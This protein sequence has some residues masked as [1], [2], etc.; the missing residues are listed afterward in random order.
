[1]RKRVFIFAGIVSCL[2]TVS[3]AQDDMICKRTTQDVFLPFGIY[4]DQD[5]VQLESD[6]AQIRQT[7]TSVFIGNVDVLHGGQ[8]LN[9]DYATYNQQTGEL[10]ASGNVRV[11]DT[12][13]V[14]QGEE[15]EWSMVDDEGAMLNVNYQTREMNARG[16]ADNV[17]RQGVSWTSMKNATYTTC[18]HGDNAWLLS[19]GRVYLDHD[20]AVGEATNVVL[21][22]K[23]L[24]VFYTP[25][26]SFPLDDERKSGFLTPSIGTSSKNGFDATTPY[27]WNIA[28]NR[29]ATITPRYMADR[30]LMLSGQYRY[31]YQRGAGQ[32]EA[33][34]LSSDRKQRDGEVLN[35]NYR[36]DRK[37][38][39]LQ[40]QGRTASNWLTQVDYNYVSDQQ[41]LEDF[42]NNL[43]ISSTTH[44]NRLLLV[45]YSSQN[46][47]LDARLHGYQT[48]ADVIKPY[49]RLPQIVFRSTLPDQAYGLTY[50]TRAEYVLFDHSDRVDGQRVDLEP[51]ISLPMATP[52]VFFTPRVALRHTR[53]DL[54]NTSNTNFD[55]TITRTLPVLSLDSGLFFDRPLS[56]RGSS[57]TQTLEPRAFYLYIPE[58]NQESIPVFDTSV[59]QFARASLYTYDR[60]TGP[61]RVGDAN[62]LTVGVTSRF[63]NNR[64]GREGFRMSIGQIRYFTN[65]D[66]SLPN[67]LGAEQRSGSDIVAE[68]VAAIARGWSVAGEMQW[69]TQ[70]DHS[71]ESSVQLRYRGDDGGIFNVGHRYRRDSLEQL[72]V[73]TALPVSPRWSVVGRYYRSIRDSRNLEMLA[74]FEYRSCCWATRLVYRDYLKYS[75]PTR[76]S[77]RRD[78]AIFLEFELNGLGSFGQSSDVLL[79][80][81]IIGY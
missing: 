4:D 9:A 81:S 11:R 66:V 57:F 67:G 3:L 34:L 51:A 52:G 42:G 58:R 43:T 23:G 39:S 55:T 60:F 59:R 48:V 49:Q 35:P 75:G 78:K 28:P 37:H 32:I 73:S 19:A 16:R 29:D 1:M 71:S 74:G 44:L 68:V 45:G 47:T 53:Y 41:Y 36:D 12:D 6:S 65:R 38:F 8:Q 50:E 70:Q 21:R 10:R 13:M 17:F 18:P 46:W 22:V 63:I 61:D 5:L 76:D 40:H 25:Y 33:G 62:Q 30:G 2:S 24:P 79:Q 54:N 27:Y 69:D 7:G 64:T 56:F 72:D 31:L 26:I 15:G 80:R 77:D 14:L 20:S